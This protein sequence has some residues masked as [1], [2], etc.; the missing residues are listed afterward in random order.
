LAFD[1]PNSFHSSA[2]GFRAPLPPINENNQRA[3]PR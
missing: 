1:Q 3:F 2:A